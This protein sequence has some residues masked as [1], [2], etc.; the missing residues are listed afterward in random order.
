MAIYAITE[1]LAALA[2]L[3]TFARTPRFFGI[4]TAGRRWVV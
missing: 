3:A 4:E 1:P 2:G